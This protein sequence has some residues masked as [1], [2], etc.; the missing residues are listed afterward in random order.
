M[1]RLAKR[2]HAR[3]YS[4]ETL[5]TK[6]STNWRDILNQLYTNKTPI[7][8]PNEDGYVSLVN[9]PKSRHVHSRIKS[10]DRHVSAN[11]TFNSF[12][13]LEDSDAFSTDDVDTAMQQH[14]NPSTLRS[15]RVNIP[16]AFDHSKV[17]QDEKE[18]SEPL[19]L[20]KS[21]SR[22]DYNRQIRLLSQKL[23]SENFSFDS[24]HIVPRPPPGPSPGRKHVSSKRIARYGIGMLSSI[25]NIIVI[26]CDHYCFSCFHFLSIS[27]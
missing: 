15:I 2:Q 12:V 25:V 24:Q 6:T 1:Q 7:N 4:P 16:R 18:P 26:I 3:K 13:N 8:T 21:I 10:R 9:Q 14:A 22:D 17:N 19:E 20:K 23:A 27:L 11:A 5:T